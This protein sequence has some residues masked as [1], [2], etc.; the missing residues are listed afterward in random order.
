M[1]GFCNDISETASNHLLPHPQARLAPSRLDAPFLFFQMRRGEKPLIF[2]A[3]W[4]II[5]AEKAGGIR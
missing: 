1:A 2:H 4:S 3:G 5:L